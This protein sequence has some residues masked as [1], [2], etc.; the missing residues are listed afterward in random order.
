MLN[1][2][3]MFQLDKKTRE[4]LGW[5]IRE[6]MLR[7]FFFFFFKAQMLPKNCSNWRMNPDFAIRA[8]PLENRG[9]WFWQYEA[10]MGCR[11]PFQ[12]IKGYSQ[13]TKNMFNLW[14]VWPTPRYI[15]SHVFANES[16]KNISRNILCL[17]LRRQR[18]Q[19]QYNS[20]T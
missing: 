5:V 3:K 6:T 13:Q 10:P 18:D 2:K 11:C 14:L 9:K 20:R 15:S 19:V 1:T 12:T 17:F 16:I 4:N 8:L 7:K